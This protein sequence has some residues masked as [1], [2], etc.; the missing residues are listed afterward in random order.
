MNEAFPIEV[1]EV[2][3]RFGHRRPVGPAPQ[4]VLDRVN[5]KVGRG[6]IVC[7]LGPSGCG[8]TTLVNLIMGITVPT[9]GRVRVLG[10]E[11][12]YPIVRP[13]IGYMPQ[14]D[15]LYNDITAIDNLRFF[16]AM[17]GMAN[18]AVT[19]KAER[20]IALMRLRGHEKKLVAQFSGGMQRR[21]S[22]AVALL[23][24]PD[25][26]V[27]DEPTVGLDPEHRRIIWDEFEAL[28][29]SGKT[30][31]VTTHIMDEALRCHQVCMLR[32]G[33]VIAEGTP[34]SLMERTGT[35]NLEDAFLALGTEQGRHG[36]K[37]DTESGGEDLGAGTGG[38]GPGDGQVSQELGE[39]PDTL[40]QG[41]GPDGDE[42]DTETGGQGP[43]EK[44]G[45]RVRSAKRRPGKERK[46][47]RHD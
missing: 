35:D 26:L 28:A 1:I 11:A 34:G 3:K 42:P 33:H 16:G 8:K 21:L 25:L 20:V 12:P 2:V 45:R 24:G 4:T 32:D 39:S 14:E 41:A 15:A 36:G 22:L 19:E 40:A 17:N 5:L 30:L 47:A 13:R 44:P 6:Q 7:L 27:L 18:R 46:E 9:S 23:H 29:A 31:L 43:G 37:P 10:E 38:Q